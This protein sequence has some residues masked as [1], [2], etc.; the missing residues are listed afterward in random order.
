M[1]LAPS[2]LWPVS[3]SLHPYLP[4]LYQVFIKTSLWI[5]P[6]RCE[7]VLFLADEATVES[8]P[9]RPQFFNFR[10]SRDLTEFSDGKPSLATVFSA[11]SAAPSTCRLANFYPFPSLYFPT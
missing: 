7:G 5:Y 8:S 6:C 3:A 1:A 10:L 4:V 9:P 11:G 2:P